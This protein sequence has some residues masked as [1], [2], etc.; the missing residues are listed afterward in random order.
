MPLRQI[1][2]G[3][4]YAVFAYASSNGKCQV[5]EYLDQLSLR[6]RKRIAALLLRVAESGPLWNT[7]KSAAIEDFFEFKSQ[8]VRIF[9]CYATGK[10][11]VLFHGFTKKSR[12]TPRNELETGRR[13]CQEVRDEITAEGV[14]GA[15]T[16]GLD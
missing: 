1:H 10:R 11:I 13:L 8:Q 7:E 12:K 9:W 14:D 16:A 4:A 2:S 15:Q 3:S 6:H 5:E